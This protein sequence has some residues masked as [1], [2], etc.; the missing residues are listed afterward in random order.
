PDWIVI[1]SG[2][3]DGARG[4]VQLTAQ[5]KPMLVKGDSAVLGLEMP[6]TIPAAPS[7]LTIALTNVQLHASTNGIKDAL[8]ISLTDATGNSLT[9]TIDP[10]TPRRDAFF[11]ATAGEAV[12]LAPGVEYQG[13]TIT[14]NLA[15]QFR[16]TA[17]KLRVRLVGNDPRT[18]STAT[19]LAIAA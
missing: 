5:C 1:E 7:L 11:N 10:G 8:E 13:Q 3:S 2:G 15:N 4:S 17:G 16:G 12:T 14:L 6:F 9:H 19:I 18:R